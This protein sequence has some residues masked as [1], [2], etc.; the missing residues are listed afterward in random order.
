[1]WSLADEVRSLVSTSIASGQA[2]GI[3]MRNAK[4]FRIG[5][6][7]RKRVTDDPIIV[8][9]EDNREAARAIDRWLDRAGIETGEAVFRS[10]RKGDRLQSERLSREAAPPC[11]QPLGWAGPCF[12]RCVL[13]RRQAV[14]RAI[15]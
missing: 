10:I 3:L 8:N 6:V 14:A 7:P 13:G 9:W 1:M 2:A 12:R 15:V 5:Q 11:R 4:D